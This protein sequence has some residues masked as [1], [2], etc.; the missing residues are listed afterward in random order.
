MK[1]CNS[2]PQKMALKTFFL[3]L[4]TQRVRCTPALWIAAVAGLVACAAPTG[5]VA[6]AD[7]TFTMTRQAQNEG[8]PAATTARATQDAEAHCV[9]MG[10]KFKLIDVKVSG[11]TGKP[12]SEVLYACE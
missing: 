3:V 8:L 6:R 10:K 12:V 5:P 11:L 4:G 9:E 1:L 2:L 7:G